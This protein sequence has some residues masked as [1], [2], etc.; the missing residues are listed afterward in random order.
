MINQHFVLAMLLERC[1]DVCNN[2]CI[3]K[4]LDIADVSVVWCAHRV[5]YV[6]LMTYQYFGFARNLVNYFQQ[7]RNNGTKQIRFWVSRW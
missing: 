1:S 5:D 2:M 4:I 6:E 7:G 3:I